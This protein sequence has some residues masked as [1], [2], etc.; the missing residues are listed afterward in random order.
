MMYA[1]VEYCRVNA[2]QKYTSFY[3]CHTCSYLAQMGI[4]G[5]LKNLGTDGQINKHCNSQKDS[6]RS[7]TYFYFI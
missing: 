3:D 6:F 5:P 2:G 1:D 7:Q 4:W